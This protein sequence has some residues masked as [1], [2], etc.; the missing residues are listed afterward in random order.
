MQKR[1]ITLGGQSYPIEELPARKNAAWRKMLA[2]RLQ[3]FLEL[4][5]QAGA[6]V[7]LNTSEDLLR[8]VNGVLPSLLQAPEMLFELLAAYAPA[9][10]EEILDAAYDSEIAE[11][12]AAVLGLAFPF[13]SLV[14]LA[15]SVNGSASTKAPISMNS[16]SPNGVSPSP[17]PLTKP[18]G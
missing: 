7:Q 15:R 5:E 16:P 6:G 2:T 4:I 13:G 8:V 10:T 18:G 9:L 14:Q 17:M 1:T 11:A 12:F 3:P